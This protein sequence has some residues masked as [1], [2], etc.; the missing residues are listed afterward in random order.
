MSDCREVL[1]RAYLFL[2]GE[3]LSETERAEIQEHLDDCAPC[4]RR[5]GLEQE[6]ATL[7]NRLRAHDPCPERLRSRI[8][9]L[10]GD[11]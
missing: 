7:V 4:F 10:L 6:V 11:I 8:V 5:Y 2:D 9:S 1:E 3:A